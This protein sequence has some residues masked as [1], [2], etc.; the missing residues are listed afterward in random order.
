LIES[1]AKGVNKKAGAQYLAFSFSHR[2][3][4]TPASPGDPANRWPAYS[5]TLD[6]ET[7]SFQVELGSASGD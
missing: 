7:R 3:H 4:D 5:L 1:A 2:A 6:V